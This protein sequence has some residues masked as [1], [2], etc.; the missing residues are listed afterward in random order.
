MNDHF[1]DVTLQT[2]LLTITDPLRDGAALD[3]AAA[4]LR[5]GKLVAI[6]TETVYGLAANALDPAAA[7]AIYAAKGRPSDNPLIVHVSSFGEIP[8]L[9][10]ELPPALGRLAERFWPGPMTVILPKSGLVPAETS[11]GLDTVAVRMPAHPV[12]RELIRR[13]GVPLAAPSANLSGSPSP[14]CAQHCIDDLAGRVDAIVDGGPCGVGVESTVLT[15][16]TDPPRVLRPGAVTLEMLREVLPDIEYDPGVF[17]HLP[18]DRKAASPGMKYKH[19]S[20]KAR[21]VLVRGTLGQFRRFIGA[22]KHAFG[23]LCFEGEE[24]YFTQRCITYGREEDPASQARR[25]F[26]ALREVDRE[27]MTLVYTRV[28]D[29]EGIGQAVYNRLLRAAGFD[30]V[31]L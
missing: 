7:K 31:L 15:L 27:G 1:G 4:L 28:S 2:K 17:E 5:A 30:E 11:G 8:P 24:T 22:Q 25:L 14:T 12:A 6:P 20:P 23:I 10:A 21:V 13:A 16:C 18:D 19:Y 29:D 26:D 3:E 9:A